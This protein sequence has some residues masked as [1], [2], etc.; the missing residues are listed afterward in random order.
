M[1]ARIAGWEIHFARDYVTRRV[2][3]LWSWERTEDGGVDAL[4]LGCVFQVS[5]AVGKVP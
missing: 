2:P 5:K 4:F 3:T 1:F